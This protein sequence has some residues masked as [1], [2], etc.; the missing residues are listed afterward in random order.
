MFLASSAVV[1][2]DIRLAARNVRRHTR[3]TAFALTIIAGGVIAFLL[4]SGFINWILYSMREATIQSQLGHLQITRPNFF[5]KGAA[6]PYS[7]LLP[8]TNLAPNLERLEPVVALA[9]RLAFG[10]LA[11]HD[12]ETIAFIGEG[13]DP[14]KEAPITRAITIVTGRDLSGTDEKAVL[15][16]EGLAKNLGASAGD[17]IV[18]LANTAS[19]NLNAIEVEIA[20]LFATAAKAYDDSVL[21]AP[22]TLARDL[23]RVE[24]STSWVVLLDDTDHTSSMVDRF[25]SLL[26]ADRFEVTPWWDLADF[27]QKTVAL[28]SKQVAL[29]RILIGAMV[30]LTISNT[31]SMAVRERTSEIGTSMALGVRRRRVLVL[32]LSEGAIL[33][34][35]GGIVGVVLASA[36]ASVISHIGIPM[37][38]PPGMARG[39]LG[40]VLITPPLALDGFILAVVTTLLASIFPARRAA[41][42]NVVDALRQQS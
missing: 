34:I 1:I 28:F 12:D 9:P 20:G 39:Y 24:G 42:M 6:D 14:A 13:I 31:L 7:Y 27:Y 2:A 4:A 36:L 10:G 15:M 18:L 26:H 25:R 16:G 22:I 5:A 11:S 19:G 35:A 40:E 21:R 3:R 30:I 17:S 37:P 32:F 38:P 29:V 23:M 8:D 33:G 41:R